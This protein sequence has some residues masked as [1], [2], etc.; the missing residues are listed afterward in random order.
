MYAAWRRLV[1]AYG[2]SG[3]PSHDTRLVAVMRVQGIKSVL[4]FNG[5][6]FHRYEAGEGITVVDP[7]NVPEPPAK[8]SQ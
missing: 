8:G 1:T 3:L 6:D 7:M 5:A 4:T 2:V